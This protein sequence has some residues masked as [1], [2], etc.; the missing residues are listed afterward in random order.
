MRMATKRWKTEQRRLQERLKASEP[1]ERQSSFFS[2]AIFT[3]SNP[4]TLYISTFSHVA[5]SKHFHALLFRVCHDQP[6]GWM[7]KRWPQVG[8][9]SK[10]KKTKKNG[11]LQVDPHN[12]FTQTHPWLQ[13][14]AI[15]PVTGEE[16]GGGG[17]WWGARW[18]MEAMLSKCR[19]QGQDTEVDLL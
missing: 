6:D 19:N 8:G 4:K 9:G 7:H 15:N 1:T 12:A 2:M 5:A 3:S 13:G 10:K 16:T 14:F 11:D 18:R 17:K